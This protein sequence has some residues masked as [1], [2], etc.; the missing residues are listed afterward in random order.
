[1]LDGLAA[2]HGDSLRV[3][4]VDATQY[5]ELAAQFSVS[6]YPKIKYFLNGRAFDYIGP[7]TVEDFQSFATRLQSKLWCK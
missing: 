5:T 2:L 3:A 1:M 4:K 6:S 7:R